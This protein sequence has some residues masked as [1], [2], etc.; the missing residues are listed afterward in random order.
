MPL[1]CL[2]TLKKVKARSG[3]QIRIVIEDIYSCKIYAIIYWQPSTIKYTNI[4]YR[5]EQ[6]NK[7]VKAEVKKKE[8]LPYMRKVLKKNF[9][10]QKYGTVLNHF[11][12]IYQK[13][14]VILQSIFIGKQKI[15]ESLRNPPVS[16]LDTVDRQN[17]VPTAL[18]HYVDFR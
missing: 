16:T 11:F 18:C 8:R 6:N 4:K 1:W 17:K 15:T 2:S 9:I 5:I 7:P 10:M 12:P 3:N 14:I 13:S